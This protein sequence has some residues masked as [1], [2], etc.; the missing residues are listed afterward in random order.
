MGT[1][2]L[3]SSWCLSGL[4][5]LDYS[6]IKWAF[7]SV[8]R[9][10]GNNTCCCCY[11]QGHIQHGHTPSIW[12]SHPVLYLF[13][14][15]DRDNTIEVGLDSSVD[16]SDCTVPACPTCWHAFREIAADSE[17]DLALTC[18]D[19]VGPC[20]IRPGLSSHSTT[21]ISAARLKVGPPAVDAEVQA[22]AL[23]CVVI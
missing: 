16:P 7:W 3:P 4:N 18:T 19:P 17:T 6:V 15:A 13:K 20:P 22:H 5:W 10:L 8:W 12:S 23:C 1:P 9:W 11:V 21:R 14:P 2:I